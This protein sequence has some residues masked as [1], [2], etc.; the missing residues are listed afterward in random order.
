M[1]PNHDNRLYR[2]RLPDLA[3][4][5]TSFTAIESSRS[6]TSTT[7]TSQYEYRS[8]SRMSSDATHFDSKSVGEIFEALNA[9][10]SRRLTDQEA[11]KL[12]DLPVFVSSSSERLSVE[13]VPPVGHVDEEQARAGPPAAVGFWHKGL[14]QTR[15][16]VGRKYSSTL[17]I[18][19]ASI[20][21]ILSIYWGILFDVKENMPKITVA[22]ISFEGIEPY[23]AYTPIVGPFVRQVCEAEMNSRSDHLGYTFLDP[24]V[25]NYDPVQVRV[26]V[27]NQDIWAAIIINSN[28]TALLRQAVETGNSSYDP[29][30]AITIVYNQA[31]DV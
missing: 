4:V 7:P 29:R 8:H 11:V 9:E 30:G 13:K 16:Q 20:V 6:D 24:S 1:D 28:A 23:R 15:K 27:Y 2:G 21:A 5:S 19:C 31:R 22:V 14:A 3:S 17:F 25:Y 12:H 18:L 26:A 10:V